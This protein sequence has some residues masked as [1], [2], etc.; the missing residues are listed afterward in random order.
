M[1]LD[2]DLYILLLSL[3]GLVRGVEPELG[4][5]A[6]TGGQITYVLE[7]ARALARHPRVARVDL[8]TRQIFDPEVGEDYAREEE[9]LGVPGAQIVRIPFGPRRYLRKELLWPHLDQLTDRLVRYLRR[10]GHPPH[11][12]HSHY[13]DAGY[14]G[15]ELSSLLGIPL[16]HTGH[17]LG[18]AKRERLLAGGMSEEA[19]R[20]RYR[21]HRRIEAE[22]RVLEHAS[23]VVCSTRQE[24]EE[25]WGA[26][27]NAYDTRL[28]VNPPGVDLSRFGPPRRGMGRPP[29]QAQIDRFFRHP[30]RPLVLALARPDPRK[31]LVRLVEAFG[32]SPLLR[33]HTNLAVVAGN[34]DD[35]RQADP[36]VAAE[37]TALLLEIDRHDLYGEV[38][39]PKHHTPAD[40][41]DL[42]R[43]AARRR[44]CFVNPALTE[45]F[46]LTL[47]EAAAS[48]LPIV[49]TDDGGPR[50]IIANCRNGVLVDALD[51]QS[52]AEGI[53]SIL[54]DPGQWRR[55]R[56]AG[57][58]GVRRHY[59]WEAHVARYLKEV[60]QTLARLRP[61]G[62]PRHRSESARRRLLRLDRM[63]V[64]DIDNT[65]VGDPDSL[66][67]LLALLAREHDHLGFAVAT[68]RSRELTLE[69]LEAE[70]IP[71]PDVLICS[72]GTE[73]YEGPN[74]EPASGW[75]AHLRYRWNR[76]GVVAA[77]EGVPGLTL[78]GPE[79]QRPFKVSYYT[80]GTQVVGEACDGDP[81]FVGGRLIEEEV[82]HRLRAAGLRFTAIFSHG[83]Y[84]D[85]L[86]VR[87]SKGKAIRYL[88]DKWGL[89]VD[90][91]LVAGDSGNDEEMLRG[92]TL[93]VV[94]GNHSPELDPL[95]GLPRIY[96]AQAP[97]AAGILEGIDHYR[98]LAR[99][100]G[101][102]E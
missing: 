91:I 62:L 2:R 71:R 51:P 76:D 43:L 57:L 60:D 49:A 102:P 7:L 72:V 69:V 32:T 88:A 16:V 14:V 46:G 93:A 48:G 6:D 63:L 11:V 94:V 53:T 39:L 81:A 24:A 8:V 15:R 96:F 1:A 77:L 64:C 54:W 3:H 75:E 66:E 40:V 56:R 21:I 80:D 44:G 89:P 27:E 50:D 68:G 20:R 90:H 79:G 36:A 34:R 30:H 61:R 12:I 4:R 29:I 67:R 78:Q 92:D 70:G 84:L 86:P 35:L 17:S 100:A 73:I 26:Y 83:Q 95:R 87:A 58:A 23:F 99:G 52:I 19:I 82:R 38:A 47:L 13:A 74:L 45:P 18:R 97:Y 28:V 98:F 22:E 25:Q 5:D 85:V 31:N 33:E 42:Y 9:P 37:I 59:T 65:L 101:I 10:Q 55:F 41:P